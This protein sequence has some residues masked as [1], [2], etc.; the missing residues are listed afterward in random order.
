MVSP[1]KLM[2]LSQAITLVFIEYE[3]VYTCMGMI[4]LSDS[5]I[6]CI[7]EHNVS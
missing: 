6:H 1:I 7:D 4:S 2:W 5:C 3:A